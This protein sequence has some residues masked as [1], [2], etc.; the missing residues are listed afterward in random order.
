MELE[1]NRID[2]IYFWVS[3]SSTDNSTPPLPKNQSYSHPRSLKRFI[4][5]LGFLA[6]VVC[7]KVELIGYGSPDKDRIKK[8]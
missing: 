8:E 1:D 2:W 5:I 4:P 7:T 3:D 6:I